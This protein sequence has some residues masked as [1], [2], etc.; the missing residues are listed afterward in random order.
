MVKAVFQIE[1]ETVGDLITL[2]GMEGKLQRMVGCVGLRALSVKQV[3]SDQAESVQARLIDWIGQ[4]GGSAS[5]SDIQRAFGFDTTDDVVR[6][7]QAL[8]DGGCGSWVNL[9]MIKPGQSIRAFELAACFD[10]V[11]Q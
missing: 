8:V 5:V 3:D 10:Q 9:T 2:D 4:Q 11:E 1:V 6:V 7:L